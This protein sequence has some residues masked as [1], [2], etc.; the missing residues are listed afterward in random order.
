MFCWCWPP[1]LGNCSWISSPSLPFSPSCPWSPTAVSFLGHKFSNLW[2]FDIVFLWLQISV[3]F[4]QQSFKSPFVLLELQ[5]LA[6]V[7]ATATG[8]LICFCDLYHWILNPLSEAR[9]QTHIFMDTSLVH[10]YWATA[11]TPAFLFL[12][13]EKQP[14][15]SSSILLKHFA[16]VSFQHCLV[17]TN[18]HPSP[19]QHVCFHCAETHATFFLCPALLLLGVVWNPSSLKTVV[20]YHS[21]CS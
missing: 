12:S 5:L 21:K 14:N 18:L 20:S 11:G 7:T 13:R 16:F 17:V 19:C 3:H 8:D 6:Y 4:C 10:Y 2:A 9:D 15:A 1:L